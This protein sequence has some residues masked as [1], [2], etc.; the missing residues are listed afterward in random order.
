MRRR[1]TL[2]LVLVAV[3]AAAHVRTPP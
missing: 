3:Q 1:L 2:L